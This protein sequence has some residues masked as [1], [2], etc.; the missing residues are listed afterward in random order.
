MSDLE[1]QSQLGFHLRCFKACDARTSTLRTRILVGLAS[2]L[3][4][5]ARRKRIA[6][7]CGDLSDDLLW[8][9]VACAVLPPGGGRSVHPGADSGPQEGVYVLKVVW[10]GACPSCMSPLRFF[11]LFIFVGQ[12]QVERKA[13]AGILALIEAERCGDSV[14]RQLLANL[15]R[16]YSAL[17]I[18][19]VA[20]QVCPLSHFVRGR[21]AWQLAHSCA[22]RRCICEVALHAKRTSSLSG[23][24]SHA[25]LALC[26]TQLACLAGCK[27]RDAD[28]VCDKGAAN[29]VPA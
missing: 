2:S 8:V 29:H 4:Q 19:E 1:S 6:S 3:R 26:P 15:L 12:S 14:D 11:D 24:P 10:R 27:M 20:F 16:C 13:V 23:G 21:L 18:Y 5:M 25:A 28:C 17:G 22:W 7:C 9:C